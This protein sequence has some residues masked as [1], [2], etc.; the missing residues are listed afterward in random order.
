MYKV[1][2]ELEFDSAHRLFGYT[3]ACQRIHG[4]CY[5]VLVTMG[6]YDGDLDSLGMVLDFKTIKKIQKW[7]DD[8]WDHRM[9]LFEE[10]DLAKTLTTLS[11]HN[12][13]KGLQCLV[14]SMVT[15]PFNPT[16][17]NMAMYLFEV[18]KKELAKLETE[19]NVVVVDIKVFETP[20]SCA[21]YRN[22]NL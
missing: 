8:N 2:K 5:K 4:H 7:L 18:A 19:N 17:E 13:D 16:A 10:D 15:V 12:N 6:C 20:T 22:P 21:T 9:I 1:T 11:G 3:G 14:D